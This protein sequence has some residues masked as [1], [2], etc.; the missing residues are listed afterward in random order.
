MPFLMSFELELEIVT[1][2]W[3]D[4]A[5]VQFPLNIYATKRFILPPAGMKVRQCSP[6]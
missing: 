1:F 3:I 6:S 5:S 4:N 2:A